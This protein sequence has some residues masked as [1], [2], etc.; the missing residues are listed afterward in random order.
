MSAVASSPTSFWNRELPPNF[1]REPCLKF[2]NRFTQ[3]LATGPCYALLDLMLRVVML[4]GA[5]LVYPALFAMAFLMPKN[6]NSNTSNRAQPQIPQIAPSQKQADALK[7]RNA[8]HK[9]AVRDYLDSVIPLMKSKFELRANRG[10]TAIEFRLGMVHDK[11]KVIPFHAA[12]GNYTETLE[13]LRKKV[14]EQVDADQT[15]QGY[16]LSIDQLITLNLKRK[17]QC[18]IISLDRQQF[19]TTHQQTLEQYQQ[20]LEKGIH[21]YYLAPDRVETALTKNKIFPYDK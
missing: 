2:H 11:L 15:A 17:K 9:Q 3:P 14:L 6:E 10:A 7:E 4:A 1:V 13:D 16:G 18:E 5:I 20:T 21:T 8:Q 19:R 12:G